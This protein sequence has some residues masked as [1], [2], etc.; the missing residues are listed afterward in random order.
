MKYIYLI[1]LS[2]LLNSNIFSQAYSIILS[3]Y[4]S[5]IILDEGLKELF[6]SIENN[7]ND[8]LMN[9]AEVYFQGFNSNVLLYPMSGYYLPNVID[10]LS[11]DYPVFEMDGYFNIKYKYFPK[12]LIIPPNSIK[13]YLVKILECY[14]ENIKK[15]EWEIIPS[16]SFA[17]K[18]LIDS[19]IINDN[20]DFKMMYNISCLYEDTI[21]ISGFT[22]MNKEESINI[23]NS[24]FFKRFLSLFNIRKY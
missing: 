4:P 18:Y 15:R 17:V 12:I 11:K 1:F 7:S 16:M 2:I 23:N 8:T 10:F 20:P 22:D 13:T 14:N 6:I 21:S 5:K 9:I 24:I 19:L 3:T